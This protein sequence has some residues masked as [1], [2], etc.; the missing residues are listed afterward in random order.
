MDSI[1][2]KWIDNPSKKNLI[3]STAI[4]FAGIFLLILS[5]TDFFKESFFSKKYLLIYLLMILATVSVVKIHRNYWK[6]K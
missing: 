4:W 1:K 2:N 3:I 6:N 5:L